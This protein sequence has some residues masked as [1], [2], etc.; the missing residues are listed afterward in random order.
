[1]KCACWHAIGFHLEQEGKGKPHCWDRLFET[2]GHAKA[3]NLLPVFDVG[4]F[5][6]VHV[7]IGAQAR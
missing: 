2:A 7:G 1:M 5:D 4:I 6:F 3:C